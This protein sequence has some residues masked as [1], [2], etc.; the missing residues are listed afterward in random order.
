MEVGWN[1]THHELA[2]FI[3]VLDFE[4]SYI[5]LK[6]ELPWVSVASLNRPN[7]ERW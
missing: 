1:T 4:A 7:R 2:R 6:E 3:L 5:A